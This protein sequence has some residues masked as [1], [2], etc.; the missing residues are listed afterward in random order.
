MKWVLNVA[1]TRVFAVIVTTHAAVPEHPP[2]LHP[3][4]VEVKLG[5]AAS[6][7]VVPVTK[8]VEHRPAGQLMPAGALVTVPRPVPVRLTVSARVTVVNVAVTSVFAVRVT[9]HV[10]APVHPP[11]LHPAKVEVRLGVAASVT[12]VPVTKLVEHRPAGQL[13][14]AGALVTVPRPVPVKLTVSARVTVVNVAVTKVSAVRV[15]TH[16]AVPEHPPLHPARV[17][18]RLGVAA[19][20]T[21]VPVTKLVEHRPAGQLMPAGALV[22]VPRPVPVKLT[23]SAR[24]TVVNVAVTKVSAVRVTTHVAVP[25]HPPPLHPAKVE[26]RLGVAASVTVVPVTK[27]VEHRPAGQLMPAGALVTVPR[28]VPVRLTVSARV[29]AVNVAVTS[30]SAVRVTTHVA[31]PVHPPPLHPAKVEVRLGVAASVTMVPVTKLVEHRPAGQ[32]MPAG[33]LVTAPRPVPVKLTVSARVIVVNVAVTKVSAVRV[34]THAAVPVHPPPL[35]PARVEVRLGVA[36]SVTV[37]PVTKLVEQGPAGQ[38]MPAGVLATLP[39]PVPVRLTVSARV[40]AVNVAVTRVFAVIVTTHAAVP[41]HPPPLHPAK[42]EVK[43]GAAVSVTTVPK[44]NRLPGGVFDTVPLPLPARL[45][46]KLYSKVTPTELLLLAVSTSAAVLVMVAV[47]VN[48]A[49][50]CTSGLTMPV[51]VMT[52]PALGGRSATC[53]VK[54]TLPVGVTTT[55]PA[56]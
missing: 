17:E 16:V 24:V 14:P 54:D 45:I 44:S 4:K 31:A 9:T 18:V 36:A 56:R 52:P 32:L 30:V 43:L 2:P 33:A 5:V 26:V 51:I 22:T 35:H 6:V 25:E 20:V 37:V 46:A 48:P 29:M 27:L 13:M 50:P 23:V 11:P 40:M 34:T 21:V 38:L 41:E 53:Q 3:A 49:T 15:T 12:V 39:V 8:L 10:A 7:T 42:V 55:P 28:P 47:L 1:V 19:N